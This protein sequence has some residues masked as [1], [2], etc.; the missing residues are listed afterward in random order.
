M[1]TI[2][3]ETLGR[4]RERVYEMT[5]CSKWR[6]LGDKPFIGGANSGFGPGDAG[7]V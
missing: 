5:A 2:V 3:K 4:F 7:A 6:E 1:C